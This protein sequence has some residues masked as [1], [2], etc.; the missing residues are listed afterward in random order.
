M[1]ITIRSLLD[2][3]PYRHEPSKNNNPE[4]N[5]FVQYSTWK[6]LLLD[7]LAKETDL[8]AKAWLDRYVRRNGQEMLREL[9]KQQ[10][11]ANANRQKILKSPYGPEQTIH[12]DYPALIND[13]KAAVSAVHP[14]PNPASSASRPPPA[15]D[16]GRAPKRKASHLQEGVIEIE[17]ED[18]EAER[19][20]SK[21]SVAAKRPSTPE[22]IDLT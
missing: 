16:G 5:R 9:S 15:L 18:E 17:D 21:T 22:I 2:D 4:F 3:E 12:V 11:A 20:R 19:K 14:E 8:T 13:L 10:Q 6:C 1:L 7:Y